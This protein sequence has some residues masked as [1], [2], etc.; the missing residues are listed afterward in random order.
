LVANKVS[1]KSN[2]SNKRAMGNQ[3]L[4]S[5]AAATKKDDE[6]SAAEKDNDKED[7]RNGKKSEEEVD[8]SV[9]SKAEINDVISVGTMLGKALRGVFM[10]KKEGKEEETKEVV[11]EEKSDE[12]WL[13][14]CDEESSYAP[15]ALSD[16]S[17]EDSDIA[18]VKQILTGGGIPSRHADSDDESSSDEEEDEPLTIEEEMDLLIDSYIDSK[19]ACDIL[20]NEAKKW[21]NRD[22]ESFVQFLT[23]KFDNRK[24]GDKNKPLKLKDILPTISANA[25]Y[26]LLDPVRCRSCRFSATSHLQCLLC[27][28][29]GRHGFVTKTNNPPPDND[30]TITMTDTTVSAMS[31][32]V[33]SGRKGWNA[34]SS[35]HLEL[36]P[37]SKSS[38]GFKYL[39]V[40][41]ALKGS[42][43]VFDYPMNL[44]DIINLTKHIIL[45]KN[46]NNEQITS[47]SD[48]SDDKLAAIAKEAFESVG[49]LVSIFKKA[50]NILEVTVRND[51]LRAAAANKNHRAF[52]SCEGKL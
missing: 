38:D 46:T 32:K 19:E 12:G 36:R 31:N 15:A 5:Q 16:S 20:D 4:I 26:E 35:L 13:E 42:G 25:A 50:S 27:D 7:I 30:Y 37:I 45:P 10:D 49:T 48:L 34:Q 52:A 40:G 24:N 22:L 6:D 18:G 9:L 17:S 11:E 23:K 43:I 51:L 39:Q 8:L 2:S 29:T 28:E 3:K 41:T 1:S 33:E 47:Y 14:G 44:E 21:A